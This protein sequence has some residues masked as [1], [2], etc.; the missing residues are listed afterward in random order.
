LADRVAPFADI[1]APPVSGRSGPEVMERQLLQ[2]LAPSR[3]HALMDGPSPLELA[4]GVRRH[5]GEDVVQVVD[6]DPGGPPGL[7]QGRGQPNGAPLGLAAGPEH[8][9]F[10][11]AIAL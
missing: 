5:F 8:L 10:Q 3:F 11:E 7:G 4:K 1:G 9:A 6:N 2:T